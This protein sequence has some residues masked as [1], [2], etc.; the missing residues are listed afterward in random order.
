MQG[1]TPLHVAVS[2][3]QH[4]LSQ[5]TESSQLREWGDNLDIEYSRHDAE[6]GDGTHLLVST[7]Y[8]YC[9]HFLFSETYCN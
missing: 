5:V 4:L 8:L 9:R 6:R 2:S 3:K 1:W 7:P